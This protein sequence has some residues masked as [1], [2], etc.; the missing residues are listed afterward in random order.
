MLF[1]GELGRLFQFEK[2]IL[3]IQDRLDRRLDA[4]GDHDW[5]TDCRETRP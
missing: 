2:P 3:E 1:A 4:L 5:K